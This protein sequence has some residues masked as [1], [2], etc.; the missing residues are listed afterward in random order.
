M[1]GTRQLLLLLSSRSST[2]LVK[3]SAAGSDEIHSTFNT[4]IQSSSVE[5]DGLAVTR[6]PS[7]SVPYGSPVTLSFSMPGSYVAWFDATPLIRAYGGGKI[8]AWP[9]SLFSVSPSLAGPSPTVSITLNSIP[10]EFHTAGSFTFAFILNYRDTSRD[11]EKQDR[12]LDRDTST[13]SSRTVQHSSTTRIRNATVPPRAKRHL[14]VTM[15]P[16]SR[17]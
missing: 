14:F 5:L 12:S 2:T 9:S 10:I 1:E 17:L 3:P 7:E 4:T 11:G 15:I 16:C 13:T 6:V 8:Y